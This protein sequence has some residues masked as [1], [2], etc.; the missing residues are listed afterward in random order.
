MNL[1]LT[2]DLAE[3]ERLVKKVFYAVDLNHNGALERRE[4]VVM[5]R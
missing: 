5:M 1:T 4:M 2:D 3:T